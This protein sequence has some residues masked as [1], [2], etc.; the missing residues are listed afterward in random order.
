MNWKRICTFI[1]KILLAIG[2]GFGGAVMH[3]TM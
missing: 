1:G 3:G 2:A